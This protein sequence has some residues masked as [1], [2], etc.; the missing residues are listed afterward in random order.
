MKSKTNPNLNAHL[1]DCVESGNDLYNQLREEIKSQEFNERQI[2]KATNQLANMS[3]L[4]LS[5]KLEAN[6]NDFS[7]LK[8]LGSIGNTLELDVKENDTTTRN[9]LATSKDAHKSLIN[10]FDG[11]KCTLGKDQK[12]YQPDLKQVDQTCKILTDKD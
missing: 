6:R 5:A 4:K 2:S 1:A 12:P 11:M 8:N 3:K 10:V 7:R 9:I